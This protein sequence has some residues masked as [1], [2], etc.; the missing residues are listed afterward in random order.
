M[1][2][3]APSARPA[4]CAWSD[5]FASRRTPPTFSSWAR[6]KV[7]TRFCWPNAM[8]Y[9]E[10]SLSKAVSNLRKARFVQ[11]LLHAETRIRAG[12]SRGSDLA[13][14]GKF[15]AVFCS[16]LIYHLPEPWKLTHNF[17]RS[18]P[19]Y[20]SGPLCARSGAKAVARGLRGK[21]HLEGGGAEPLSGMSPTAT[22][23]TLE[24]LIATL[25]ASGYGCV[26]VMHHDPTHAN[27]P[28]VTIG[29]TVMD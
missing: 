19:G 21:I 15:D 17:P 26:H 18:R 24:S 20:S 11:E 28:A 12:E 1:I 22:W 6:W 5:F 4:T 16:G 25:T 2:M 8:G 29:A 13:S 23:L 10:C 27:G 3:A 7:R 14:L 9:G